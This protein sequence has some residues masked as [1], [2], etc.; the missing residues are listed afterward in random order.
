MSD[1]LA[2]EGHSLTPVQCSAI[3][4]KVNAADPSV[5]QVFHKYI[6][7]RL[8]A[9]RKLSTPFGRE[10]YFFGLRAGEAGSNNKIFN[11]A[12]SYIPQSTVG[13]NTGFA[14]FNLETGN[15][16]TRGHILQECHDSIMQEINDNVDTI[17][18]H[19]QETKKAFDRTIRFHNGIEVRIPIEGE[20]GYDFA[21]SVTFKARNGSKRLDDITYSDVQAVWYKLQELKEREMQNAEETSQEL[22]QH[23]C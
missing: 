14:V 21:E 7:D 11:E 1:S 8:Y 20:I 4:A 15:D 19:I 23:V 18:D 12:F 2:K 3:L 9:E 10:R 16:K 22:D 6:K 5:D 17:W 13:D